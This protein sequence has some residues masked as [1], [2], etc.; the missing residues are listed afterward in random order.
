M[1]LLLITGASAGIGL[2]TARRF[3]DEGYEIVNLSR[4]RCPLAKV[5]HINCDLAT[6]RFLDNISGQLGQ[7][8]GDAERVTL[9][10]NAARLD[11]D[12]A[13][14]T[15][16]N[17]CRFASGSASGSTLFMDESPCVRS[18]SARRRR[19]WR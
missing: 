3:A 12:T 10:H 16:S 13:V 14:E 8:L 19:R 6:P 7:L 11:N 18:S 17:A 4:R 9:I 5:T 15:P 2:A 1:N